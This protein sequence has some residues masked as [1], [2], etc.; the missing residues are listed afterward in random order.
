MPALPA[1]D[2]VA[3][4]TADATHDLRHR[5]AEVRARTRALAAPLSAE[6]AQIQSMPDASPAKWHLAHTTWFFARFVLDDPAAIP[7]GW[8]Y[9][10]NSYYVGAGERHP[11]ALRGQ[12]SRPSLAEVL[13]W[14][15]AVDERVLRGLDE[16][17]FDDA[18]RDVLLL[19]THHEQQHQELL[20]TDIKHALWCNPLAPAYRN[21]LPVPAA[22]A[23][24]GTAGGD[25]RWLRRGEAIVKIGAPR[26]PGAGSAF[27]YDN[28]TPRHRVLVPAHA[29]AEQPVSNAQFA[30]F[31][32]DG[33]YR[34]PSLWLSDGWDLVQREAWA[35][36]LYWHEDGAREFTLGG[37]RE[38]DPDAP[39]CHLSHYEADAFAHW[40]GA[41]LPT[42]AEWEAAAA[43][44][45]AE[46]NFA[47]D[48]APL[49]PVAVDG[50]LGRS[51]A[52]LGLFGNAW[53]W[54]SSA[55]APWPGF[56]PLAGTLG[57]Y[58]GKFMSGQLVLRGGSCATPRGHARASYR[59]FF[60]P[61]ARWQFSGLRLAKDLD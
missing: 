31:V 9:L 3:P 58:N 52:P 47:D 6:D 43:G 17:R 49:H 33:G 16:G 32:A 19:G 56:R 11:R 36:P 30:A 1:A 51:T 21:D 40:A 59:N 27:A 13:A 5:Y 46:G 7:D 50:T 53:E 29:L 26:W 41:R 10:F 35:R 20:L 44:L 38:R 34:T 60:A 15:D 25:P 55:Y 18:T 39:A 4:P 2:A 61:H 54:T 45:P 12:V 42:E 57:E 23:T 48:G 37:W 22:P 24:A 28:E 14:R 8:D